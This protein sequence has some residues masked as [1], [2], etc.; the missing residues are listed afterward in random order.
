M[1]HIFIAIGMALVLTACS[2]VQTAKEAKGTGEVKTYSQPIAVVWPEIKKA[3]EA[4]DGKVEEVND[5]EYYALAS[6]GVGA[7]SW[8]EKVAIFCTPSGNST[9]VEI[10]NKAKLK[11][12]ITATNNAPKIFA[13]LDSALKK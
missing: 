1:K 6:Y 4:T 11:T 8:G 3:V 12:N 9:R 5:V 7:F 10:V 13:K 2:S